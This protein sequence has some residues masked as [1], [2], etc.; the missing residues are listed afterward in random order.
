VPVERAREPAGQTAGGIGRAE[1][2]AVLTRLL[3]AAGAPGHDAALRACREH[4]V[5]QSGPDHLA[6]QVPVSLVV[7]DDAAYARLR[8]VDAG[9]GVVAARSWLRPTAAR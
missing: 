1:V 2:D 9:A 5:H 4:Q 7:L 6:G 8:G 3:P